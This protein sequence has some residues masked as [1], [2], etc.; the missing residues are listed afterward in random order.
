MRKYKFLNGLALLKENQDKLE[1][2]SFS[3]MFHP[4]LGHVSGEHWEGWL[5]GLWLDNRDPAVRIH[6]LGSSM[7]GIPLLAQPA[8]DVHGASWEGQQIIP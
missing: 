3:V 6:S 2:L 1:T 7:V 8:T 4:F 5:A